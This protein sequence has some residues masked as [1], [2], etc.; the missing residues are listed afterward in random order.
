M[1][2][3]SPT[4]K[5]AEVLITCPPIIQTPASLDSDSPTP[6]VPKDMAQCSP[7]TISAL[8]TPPPSVIHQPNESKFVSDNSTSSSLNKKQ[9]HKQQS[10]LA[11]GLSKSEFEAEIMER[12]I[13]SLKEELAARD[14][15][16]KKE[17]EKSSILSQRIKLLESKVSQTISA[18]IQC[19]ESSH[20]VKISATNVND[21]IVASAPENK[22]NDA[23]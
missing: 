7:T 9:T 6:D 18:K 10:S 1:P 17:R 22:A 8:H 4:D 12:M 19:K 20:P 15:D 13:V 21:P 14:A 23:K 16:L 11:P 3:D 2:L 5:S